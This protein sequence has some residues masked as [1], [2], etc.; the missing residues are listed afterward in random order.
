MSVFGTPKCVNISKNTPFVF[1]QNVFGG[2]IT[3][4]YLIIRRLLAMSREEGK[5]KSRITW[6]RDRT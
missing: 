6:K 1:T 4:E 5:R 2:I 3:A